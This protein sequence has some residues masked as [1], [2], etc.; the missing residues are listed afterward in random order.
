MLKSSCCKCVQTFCFVLQMFSISVMRAVLRWCSARSSSSNVLVISATASIFLSFSWRE[1][2]V[3][4]SMAAV[5][6]GSLQDDTTATLLSELRESILITW[7]LMSWPHWTPWGG[8]G[9]VTWRQIHLAANVLHDIYICDVILLYYCIMLLFL[10]W[11]VLTNITSSYGYLIFVLMAAE[12]WSDTLLTVL[13]LSWP[14]HSW[15]RGF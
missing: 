12:C 3:T 9:G 11:S 2:S 5:S 15:K 8:G 6:W 1:I 4:S 14:G 7:N 10:L 13:V